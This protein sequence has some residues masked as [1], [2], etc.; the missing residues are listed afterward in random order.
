MCHITVVDY[1]L[2]NPAGSFFYSI[3]KRTKA[4]TLNAFSIAIEGLTKKFGNFTAVDNVSFTI[5][6]GES[7]ALI[8]PNGAGKSTIIK[9][10]TT[11]TRPDTGEARVA[12]YDIVTQ[13]SEV[14]QHIGY[15]PQLLS[16]DGALTAWENMLLSAR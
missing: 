5:S 4:V 8:G 9:M 12:G 13:A 16:A 3:M 7:F 14:R 10:L 6:P 2:N 15:I 11:L 1:E